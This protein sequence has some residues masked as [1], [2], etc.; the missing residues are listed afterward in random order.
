M[1]NIIHLKEF[2]RQKGLNDDVIPFFRNSSL[3]FQHF[4]EQD[5][6]LFIVKTNTFLFFFLLFIEKNVHTDLPSIQ[7]RFQD[8]KHNPRISKGE[9]VVEHIYDVEQKMAMKYV[10]K[11][12]NK[13]NGIPSISLLKSRIKE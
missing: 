7:D 6:S 9:W 4:V 1:D 5:E 11:L 12:Q 13:K 3:S 10:N 2:L 8:I